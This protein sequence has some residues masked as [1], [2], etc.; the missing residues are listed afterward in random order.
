MVPL[1]FWPCFGKVEAPLRDKRWQSNMGPKRD[2]WFL[3]R[4]GLVW[5]GRGTFERKKGG[6]RMWDPK[7]NGDTDRHRKI[8]RN[9]RSSLLT[10]S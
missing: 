8:D 9:S 1:P 10:L 7:Q 4:F 5:K 3:C 2:T 6:T